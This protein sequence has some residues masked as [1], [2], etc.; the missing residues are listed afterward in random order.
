[1]TWSAMLLWRSD[2]RYASGLLAPSLPLEATGHLF[3]RFAIN[4]RRQAFGV[5]AFIMKPSPA[6][7]TGSRKMGDW[8]K[9][10]RTH[11][12]HHTREEAV[13]AAHDLA[14]LM[15]GVPCGYVF[16]VQPKMGKW[17]LVSLPQDG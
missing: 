1:M 11:S 17:A 3:A 4:H 10:R 14:R 6:T 16:A 15:N 9:Y 12:A 2:A 7:R 5:T 8:L 13:E